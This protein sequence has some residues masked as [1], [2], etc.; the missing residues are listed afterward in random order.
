VDWMHLVKDRQICGLLW[1]RQWT[2]SFRNR[3]QMFWS[4]EW[5]LSSQKGPC[6]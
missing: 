5:L 6:W 2:F 1:T 3:P 4:A